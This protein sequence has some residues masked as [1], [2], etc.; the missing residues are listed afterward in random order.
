MRGAASLRAQRAPGAPAPGAHAAFHNLLGR[1]PFIARR[2]AAAQFGR[3]RVLASLP[4][5][6][7][8]IEWET[9]APPEGGEDGAPTVVLRIPRRQD[10]WG[11]IL[12]IA[13]DAGRVGSSLEAVY[14]GA[15]GGVIALTKT[16]ALELAKANITVNTV[17][18]GFTETDMFAEI[19]EKIQ[20]QI[21]QR[22]P[23]GRFGKPEEIAKAVIFLAADGDYITGQ[24][25]NVNGG[26][27]M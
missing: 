25:I 17:S 15:K 9:R 18:P 2:R 19:P 21:K 26:A 23:M 1:I 24:Q 4:Y 27:Y 10:R 12:N 14:S 3:H 20:D 13:S 8:L 6:N 16:A 5:R 22:I 7:P 11:R